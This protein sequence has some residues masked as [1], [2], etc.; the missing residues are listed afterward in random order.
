MLSLIKRQ[1]VRKVQY[2]WCIFL[3]IIMVTGMTL[4]VP[5]QNHEPITGSQL[6]QL[7][8]DAEQ[9]FAEI[10]T[11]KTLF[12]QEKSLSLFA[13]PVISKG[14]CIFK[15]PD[16][17]RLEYTEPFKS[18][19]LV[20]HNQIYK[21]EFYAG[22]WKKLDSADKEIMLTVMGNIGSWLKGKFKDPQVYDISAMNGDKKTIFLV[23]K[24]T[25]FKKFIRSF[26]LGLNNHING[27]DY[28]IIHE[29]EKD[30]T[31]ITFHNDVI[32]TAV[33][34]TV[35]VGEEDGPQPVAQW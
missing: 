7:L 32:N 35:F 13:E 2:P 6:N 15:A 9:N 27:L 26:E 20:N 5:G 34:D 3:T 8:V 29:N 21:Y 33:S 1:N 14:F 28:I 19:L 30:Y 31:K 25:A 24:H 11:I 10:N 16:Q 4:S 18:S 12:T 22:Q 17:I 23:P